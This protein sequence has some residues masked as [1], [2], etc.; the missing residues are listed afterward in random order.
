MASISVI[1]NIGSDPVLKFYEGKNGSFGVC[2]FNLAETERVKDSQGNWS[3]GATIWYRVSVL[4]KQAEVIADSLGKGERVKVEGTFKQ[5][6][7]QGKDGTEKSG[8][9]IKADEITLVLKPN[10]SQKIKPQNDEPAWGNT[11]N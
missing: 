10:K 8:L 11:W 1:G 7:Y 3:D 9:E 4:G 6:S 2:S 5:S